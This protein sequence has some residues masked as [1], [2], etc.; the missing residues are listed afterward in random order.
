MKRHLCSGS[1][2]V[3]LVV[4]P[5]R[6]FLHLFLVGFLLFLCTSDRQQFNVTGGKYKGLHKIEPV[7]V[8]PVTHD[9]LPVLFAELAKIAG[10]DQL[11]PESVGSDDPALQPATVDPFLHFTSRRCASAKYS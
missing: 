3:G 10:V 4:F 11:P 5:I 2:F 6:I 8:Q 7:D 9:F 1:Q